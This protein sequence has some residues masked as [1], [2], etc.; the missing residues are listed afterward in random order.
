MKGGES[1]AINGPKH[2]SF[3]ADIYAIEECLR[4]C[5]HDILT[6]MH[7]FKLQSNTK[8]SRGIHL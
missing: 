5:Y 7:I 3:Q 2:A 1:T 6:Y 4:V 8:C